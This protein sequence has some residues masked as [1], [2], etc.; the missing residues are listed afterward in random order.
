MLENHLTCGNYTST[1]TK[2]LDPILISTVERVFMEEE[3]RK[4]AKLF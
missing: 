1:S 2:R 3:N 4:I